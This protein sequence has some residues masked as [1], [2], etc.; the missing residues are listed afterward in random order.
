[1]YNNMILLGSQGNNARNYLG[2]NLKIMLAMT[3]MYSILKVVLGGGCANI[4]RCVRP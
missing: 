2:N 4:S 1:M 3:D